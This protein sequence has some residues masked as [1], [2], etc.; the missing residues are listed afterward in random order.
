MSQAIEPKA[1]MA[2]VVRGHLA[3][4]QALAQELTFLLQAKPSIV[5]VHRQLSGSKL[6]IKEGGDMNEEGTGLQ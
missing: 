3:E 2:L 5:V 4:I 1:N 6:W